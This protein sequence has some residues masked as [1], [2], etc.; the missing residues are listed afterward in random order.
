MIAAKLRRLFALDMMMLF[1]ES[2]LISIA[3]HLERPASFSRILGN[4]MQSL[5]PSGLIVVSIT[6]S[7]FFFVIVFNYSL[8]PRIFCIYSICFYFFCGLATSDT[9]RQIWVIG[10][11]S[12]FVWVF[13]DCKLEVLKVTG[14][15]LF[16]R[17]H[18]PIVVHLIS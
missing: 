2:H 18:N 13:Y 15:K 3:S 11:K 1:S 14:F 8:Y 5:F 12:A 6:L 16:F 7:S 4:I 10:N 17:L 9:P